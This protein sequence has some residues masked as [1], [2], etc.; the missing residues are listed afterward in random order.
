LK[1]SITEIGPGLKSERKPAN[2]LPPFTLEL[3]NAF[4]LNP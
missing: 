3:F 2:H 1:G 4:P